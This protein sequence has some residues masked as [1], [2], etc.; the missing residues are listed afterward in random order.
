MAKSDNQVYLIALGSN[1]RHGL[2]GAPEKILEHAFAALEMDDV[3]IFSQSRVMTSRPIGPSRRLFANACALLTT[4]L[5]PTEM[6]IKLKQVEQ[7]FGRQYVGQ[8][9][10]DRVLDLDIILWSGGIWVSS[11]P[12]L[13]IPH[14]SWKNRSF[15]LNPAAEVAAKWRDPITGLTIAHLLCRHNSPKRVDQAGKQL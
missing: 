3:N 1:R 11:Y 8:K 13:S 7:H 4:S 2:I 5:Q 14:P 15:V 10:R 12:A 9:W 6:I